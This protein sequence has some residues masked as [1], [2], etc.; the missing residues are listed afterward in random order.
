MTL[1]TGA[2]QLVVQLALVTTVCF[3]GSYVSWLTPRQNV[4]TCSG[5]LFVGAEMITR[6]APADTCLR[7]AS[8]SR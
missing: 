8:R 7:G 2:R 6:F 4:G 3:A 1:A 5:P